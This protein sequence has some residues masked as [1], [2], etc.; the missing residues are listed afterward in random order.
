[1]VF[2]SSDDLMKLNF[3]MKITAVLNGI[4]KIKS[5]E[6]HFSSFFY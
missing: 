5:N 2:N 3:Y 1:M 4:C 6:N